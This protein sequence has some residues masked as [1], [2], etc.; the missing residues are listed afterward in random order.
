MYTAEI[1]MEGLNPSNKTDKLDFYVN[2]SVS[3]SDTLNL[4][5]LNFITQ[6]AELYEQV[7]YMIKQAY[8]RGLTENP[9]NNN[10]IALRNEQKPPLFKKYWI[11]ESGRGWG[12]QFTGLHWILD[13]MGEEVNSN[14]LIYT[15]NLANDE[16]LLIKDD[17]HGIVKKL[18]RNELTKRYMGDTCYYA[19]SNSLRIANKLNII[20]KDNYRYNKIWIKDFDKIPNKKRSIRTK[21]YFSQ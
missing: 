3:K 16:K 15:P 10:P 17:I 18:H 6:D 4:R 7:G 1:V 11:I 2:G 20:K 8:H 14:F 9:N 19:L 13:A 5:F 12:K 21:K